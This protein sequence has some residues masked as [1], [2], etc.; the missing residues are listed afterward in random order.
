MPKF[1]KVRQNPPRLAKSK[2]FGIC[3][4]CSLVDRPKIVRVLTHPRKGNTKSAKNKSSPSRRSNT[5]DPK[6]P[7]R[8]QS[9]PLPKRP[10]PMSRDPSDAISIARSDANPPTSN[11][12]FPRSKSSPELTNQK[13]VQDP[14]SSSSQM[15]QRDSANSRSSPEL[16]TSPNSPASQTLTRS[17]NSLNLQNAPPGNA[18]MTRAREG[19]RSGG[20]YS[21]RVL[22]TFRSYS[23]HMMTNIRTRWSRFHQNSSS[24]CTIC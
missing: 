21:L 8:T 15:N 11:L 7:V 17:T 20:R 24:G 12:N 23:R 1:Q 6:N 10:N 22:D 19:V 2:G 13:S 14:T 9:S 5:P 16:P 18:L 4:C 3:F